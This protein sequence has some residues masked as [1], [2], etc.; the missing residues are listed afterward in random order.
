[1]SSGP[2]RIDLYRAPY[3]F[4]DE[5]TRHFDISEDCDAAETGRKSVMR[6]NTDQNPFVGK[7]VVS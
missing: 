2:G 1:M 5:N 7:N 4:L 3:I 6:L